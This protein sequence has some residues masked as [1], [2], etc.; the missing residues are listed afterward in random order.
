M[1]DETISTLAAVPRPEVSSTVAQVAVLAALAATG[2]L[3]TNILLPSLPAMA[4]SLNVSSA[5]VTSAITIFL[6]VFAVGQLVVG[7]ISDRYGRR[8]PVLAGFVVFCAGS[9]WCGLANDLPSLLTGRVIQGAGACATSVLSRAI[10]RDLFSG[11]ALARAMALIMIAMA[12]APGFSP[13]L[14]GALD[15]YFGWRS[16]FAFVGAFAA[17]G[18]LAYGA[19][20]G[21]THHATRTP[22]NPRAIARNYLGLIADRRF[23]VPAAT[24]SLIMGGLFAMF[25]AAPRILIEG[26]HFTPI[27]LGLFFAG[28]VMVV[29]TA[30]MLATRL[31]PRFGLD[32]SI[33]G[34]LVA[35]AGGSIA[36]LAASIFNPSFPSFLAAMCLFLL[37]MGIVNPLGTAQ[38]L[39]PFGEKAGAASALLGFWQMMGAAIGVWL[40]ANVSH[41]AM[42]A[43][44]IVLTIASLLAV[45]LYAMRAKTA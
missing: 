7:P 18:A 19:V 43:L 3:A 20:L 36:I 40:T 1:A 6:A 29:F 14:G 39:S 15:H 10:A 8:W 2:A 17:A 4:A 23:L 5:A 32:R 31:A 9:I 21:E 44:G 26:M 24:V 16:E 35:A 22:L 38:A 34:G 28:T 42:F 27:Q 12:A 11:A 45:A 25:S 33:R 30:G 41:A 37:G 13:L